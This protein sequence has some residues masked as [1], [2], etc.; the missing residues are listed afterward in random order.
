MTTLELRKCSRDDEII[1]IELLLNNS[2][3]VHIDLR[4]KDGR[5]DTYPF[6]DH[7]P[8][9]AE[10]ADK[11]GRINMITKEIVYRLRIDDYLHQQVFDEEGLGGST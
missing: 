2:H 10:F 4:P 7:G 6:F 1:G 3:Y 5:T 8:I 11:Q 9:K